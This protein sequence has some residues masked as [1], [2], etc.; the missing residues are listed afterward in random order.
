MAA[1]LEYGIVG[2]NDGALSTAQAPFGGYKKSGLGREG[3]SEGIE[4][5]VETKLVSWGAIAPRA[6][7]P[8]PGALG[9]GGVHPAAT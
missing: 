8:T 6:D 3:W 9:S 4:E 1:A 7:G 5:F 2:L